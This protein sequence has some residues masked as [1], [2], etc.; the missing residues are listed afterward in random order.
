MRLETE[1]ER[2]WRGM[3]KERE[4]KKIRKKKMSHRHGNVIMTDS[5]LNI[6][7]FF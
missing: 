1:M 7:I 3:K 2:S 5:C 6:L 4:N